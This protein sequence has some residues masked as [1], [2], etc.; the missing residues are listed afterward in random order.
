MKWGINKVKIFV[1]VSK[2]QISCWLSLV[3]RICLVLYTN[4]IY[5]LIYIRIDFKIHR[6]NKRI[7]NL[8]FKKDRNWGVWTLD[9]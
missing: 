5:T 2:P 9:S 3:D 6:Y 8:G 7:I 4:R 1:L